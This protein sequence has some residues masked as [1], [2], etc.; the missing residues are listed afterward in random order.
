M[1]EKIPIIHGAEGFISIPSVMAGYNPVSGLHIESTENTYVLAPSLSWVKGRHTIKFGAD[2]RVMQNTYYQTFDGGNFSF[3]QAITSRNALNQ[4][5]TGNSLASVLLGF[6]NGGS[7]TAFARP[8][9]S[10]RYQGY[11]IQDTWQVTNKLTLSAGLRWEI[12]GV[13]RE[14]Y[15]RIASFNGTEVNPVTKGI[16]INGQ[17]IL[18]ALDFVQTPQHPEKGVRTEHFNLF[19]PRLGLAY[20]LNDKTVL[21]TGAGIYYLPVNLRF[22]DAPWAMPLSHS[23][24]PGWPRWTTA[25]HRMTLSAIRIR[26]ASFRPPATFPATRLRLCWSAESSATFPCGPSLRRINRNGTSPYS[27]S[28]GEA[29]RS[30]R[31]T[32]VIPG[33]TC[34]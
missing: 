17:P 7:V 25:S 19:A 24:P 28:C 2:L 15:N 11:Y 3:N 21:R 26:T 30:R 16:T 29:W 6:G 27:G 18:G 9:Q 34:R 14:R 1:D 4:G 10:L 23:P 13:W 5:A 31:P 8:Y 33:F 20:R 32:R 22:S 12:P